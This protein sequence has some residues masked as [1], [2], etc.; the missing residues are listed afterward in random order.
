VARLGRAYPANRILQGRVIPV[1]PAGPAY[2][3]TG[4]GGFSTGGSP[5]WTHSA[6][7]GAYAVVGV[8]VNGGVT[9]SGV[10]YGGTSMAMLGNVPLNNIASNG[11]V[12]LYGLSNVSSGSKSIVVTPASA[13]ALM[14][15]S[16]S[17]TGVTSVGTAQTTFGTGTSMSQSTTGGGSGAMTVQMFGSLATAA[18]TAYSGTQ[19]SNVYNSSVAAEYVIGDSGTANK[20]FTATAT[21]GAWG[22]AA[23][24]LS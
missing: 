1:A 8:V 12:Y 23:V 10:T 16:V 9:V 20:T 4:A 2:D 14:G 15:N 19:R 5:T 7:S 17:Y 11:S 6:A 3:A 24:V 21:S 18:A 22:G 13:C